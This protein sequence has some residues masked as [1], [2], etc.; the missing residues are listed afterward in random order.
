CAKV[1]SGVAVTGPTFDY[2]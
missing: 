1:T 2:W